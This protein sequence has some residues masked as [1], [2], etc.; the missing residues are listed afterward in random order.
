[1]QLVSFPVLAL[2]QGE[3][4]CAMKLQ[5]ENGRVMA[6]NRIPADWSMNL[7]LNYGDSPI[8][9]GAAA[10]GA[11]CLSSVDELWGAVTVSEASHE[12]EPVIVSGELSTTIDFET[13]RSRTFTE[14]E[15]ILES[16]ESLGS[17]H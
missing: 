4:I 3:R 6:I 1:V 16:P 8:V 15:L 12:G 11:G 17:C 14:H 13:T 7:N 5:V 2:D 9:S 10:H